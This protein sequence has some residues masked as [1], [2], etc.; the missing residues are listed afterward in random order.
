MSDIGIPPGILAGLTWHDWAVTPIAGDASAR[1]YWRLLGP[2]DETVILLDNGAPHGAGINAFLDIGAR[3]RSA[4]LAAPDCLYLSNDHRYAVLQ[5]LG[6]LTLVDHL[7]SNPAEEPELYGLAADLI[8]SIQTV[9]APAGAAS[10]TP[11]AGAEMLGPFF[12]HAAP[13]IS[14]HEATSIALAVRDGLARHTS[15]NHVLSL[16]DFHAENLIWRP[17]EHGLSRFGLID[18]QDAFL[19]PPEYDLASRL[20]DARRDVSVEAAAAATRQFADRTGGSH[21]RIITATAMLAIQRNL[22]IL[23]IFLRLIH[24]EG[25]PRYAAFIPRVLGHLEADLS[26]PRLAPLSRTIRRALERVP[27]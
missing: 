22:R 20:R 6:R 1:R 10:L 5:D 3:L 27:A 16:R 4:G 24:A 17:D 15:Q 26:N 13:H 7:A 2:E 14:S 11:D 12:D 25:K 9:D 19:A 18:Y 23:G 21:A 8:V